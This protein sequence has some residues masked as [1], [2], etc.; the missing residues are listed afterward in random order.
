MYADDFI[1]YCSGSSAVE[2]CRRIQSG[3]NAATNWALQHGFKFSTLKTKA[4]RFCRLTRREEIPTLFLLGQILPYEEQVKYLG[5]ILDKK[6]NFNAHVTDLVVN[7]K[8]RLNI[9]KVVSNYNWG[10][11]STTLIRMYTSLCLSKLEYGCQIYGSACKT[12]LQKLDVVHNMAIRICT[13]AY[14]TSPIDSLY[15]DAGIGPL[16]LRREELGLRYMARILTS[17]LNP[18]Y[19]YVV[20]PL[21]KAPNKPRLPRPLEVRL[22]DGAREVGLF[23]PV[24]AEICP[25]KFP[26]WCC[27]A[28][29]ICPIRESKRDSSD[30]LKSSFLAHASE[31]SSSVNLYTDGSKSSDGVGCAVVS[32]STILKKKLPPVSSSFTAELFAILSALIFIFNNKSSNN[33]YVILTDSM[34]ALSSLKKTFPSRQLVKEIKDWLVLIHS[35]KKA[36]I[37]FCWV[38]SHVGISG[39]ERADVAA[40]SATRLAHVTAAKVPHF[41]FRP[42]IHDYIMGR[43]QDHWSGLQ[44]NFKLRSIHPDV[45]PWGLPCRLDRRSSVVITRL[46]IGH[47]YLTHRYLMASGAEA[48]SY[49]LYL[50]NFSYCKTCFI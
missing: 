22:E 44:G 37:K 26:P 20:R 4:I 1:L 35:R 49:L 15:V 17:K 29:N 32:E 36:R 46:R 31:H 33:S 27:P 41:D 47:T 34:S 38:P 39:N 30:M 2:V 13:G 21:D 40:K 24:I 18:N 28:V 48:G 6:L 19:K 25:S 5:M 7:V 23:P 10:A 9:L 12:T 11:D 8:Q 3:I 14:R 43:W 42:R 50:P 45:L 16:A